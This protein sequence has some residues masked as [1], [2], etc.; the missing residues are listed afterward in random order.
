MLNILTSLRCNGGAFAM[1]NLV[2]CSLD[3]FTGEHLSHSLWLNFYPE[4]W[5][6]QRLHLSTTGGTET[7][8]KT[9]QNLVTIK[10][11]LDLKFDP[12]TITDRT[13]GAPSQPSKSRASG[14]GYCSA[15]SSGGK[16]FKI[17]KFG[18]LCLA[19]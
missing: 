13:H 2:V 18:V 17:A 16:I 7:T 10:I 11:R 5:R 14:V 1:E 12:I 15:K 4:K 9:L 6:K 3:L 8:S 19:R